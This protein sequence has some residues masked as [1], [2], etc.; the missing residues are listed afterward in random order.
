MLKLR[1]RSFEPNPDC[2][3]FSKRSKKSLTVFSIDRLNTKIVFYRAIF[4]IF[5]NNV[6]LWIDCAMRVL[7]RWFEC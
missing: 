4:R 6:I 3:I 7:L 2:L 1:M 5:I